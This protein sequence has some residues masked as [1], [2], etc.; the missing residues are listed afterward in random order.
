MR[1]PGWWIVGIRPLSPS[2]SLFV[3]IPAVWNE[4]DIDVCTEPQH[5]IDNRP[6][7]DLFPATTRRLAQHNLRHLAL[8]GDLDEGLGNITALRANHLRSQVF[9]EQRMRFQP[10]LCRF[11]VLLHVSAVLEPPNELARE[12]QVALRLD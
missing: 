10:A 11:P 6:T 5:T 12:G 8:P 9:C 1:W 2:A 7:Q 4:M 3:R